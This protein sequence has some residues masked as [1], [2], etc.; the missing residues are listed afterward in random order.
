MDRPTRT[1]RFTVRGHKVVTRTPRKYI[2]VAVR[3]TSKVTE[4]GVYV[5]FATVKK[6]TDKLD[7]ARLVAR[8]YGFKLGAFAVVVDADTGKEID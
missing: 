1:L 5:G 3:P 6:R 7:A 2:V 4:D 8:R